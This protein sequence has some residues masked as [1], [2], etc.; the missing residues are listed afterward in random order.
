MFGPYM[1][2][3][4]ASFPTVQCLDMCFNFLGTNDNQD[5]RKLN[6]LTRNSR[7]DRTPYAGSISV[8]NHR[9]ERHRQSS[10]YRPPI[11]K[12]IVDRNLL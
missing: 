11:G 5:I 8:G 3:G 6:S 4:I 10:R 2:L 9:V 1:N 7:D 12:L